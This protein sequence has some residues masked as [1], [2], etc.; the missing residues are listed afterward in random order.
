MAVNPISPMPESYLVTLGRLLSLDEFLKRPLHL[1][2]SLDGQDM[3]PG[4]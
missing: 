1:T 2:E 4:F 3:L